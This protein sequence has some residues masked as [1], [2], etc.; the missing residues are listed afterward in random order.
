MNVED[1][2]LLFHNTCTDSECPGVLTGPIEEEM[3]CA[4]CDCKFQIKELRPM[5]VQ[6]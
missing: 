6:A 5:L 2:V 3:T 1:A 4:E